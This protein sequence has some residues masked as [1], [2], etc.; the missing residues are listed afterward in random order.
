MKRTGIANI[1]FLLVLIIS[2]VLFS[3][4]GYSPTS[5]YENSQPS[6]Q[7][8]IEEKLAIHKADRD[9]AIQKLKEWEE[10][11]K[12]LK[13]ELKEYYVP[14]PKDE[15]PKPNP[16]VVKG[17]YVTGDTAGSTKNI[18]H[19][20]DLL[21][22]SELNTMVIDVKDDNGLMSYKSNIQIVDD[23]EANRH[24]RI[25]DI[26]SFIKTLEDHN[27]YPIARIVTF[28]DRNLSEHRPDLSIQKKTGGIW[29]DRKGVS[30]VNPYDKRVWD[31]TIAVAKEAALNGFKEIQF[32]YVRFPENGARVDA[33]AFLPGQNGKSKDDCIAEFLSYA[34]EQLKDYNVIIS[35]DVFGLT[36][37]VEDDMNIGQKWEKI[38]PVVDYIS[39]MIYPSHY[40]AGNYGF[41]NPNAH[42]Y[43]VVDKAI[44]DAFK[45]NESLEKKA[46]IR[47]WIQDF[48]LGKPKYTGE[49]VLKQIKA[50]NDNGIEGYML[51]NAGNKY[52]EDVLIK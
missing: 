40:Y 3:L 34:R 12:V 13:E 29:R 52:S 17:I 41:D 30:W 51:W 35:A 31:Y 16:P 9:E 47:P 23:V 42:P 37:S 22:N 1:I 6:Y 36:T 25:R 15:L 19:L 21:D 32:D 18:E 4:K 44:K 27:I 20:I 43:E 39:P 50:L 48:T 49:D 11:D 5:A 7:E 26:Q 10:K 2:G 46:I 33:E 38:S 24:V 45:K 28:K 14:L 8:L